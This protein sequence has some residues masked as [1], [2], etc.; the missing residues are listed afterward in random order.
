MK[1]HIKHSVR[2]ICDEEGLTLE[3]DYVRD[4]MGRE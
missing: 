1:D 3:T 4:D 2:V